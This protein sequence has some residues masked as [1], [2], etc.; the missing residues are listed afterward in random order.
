LDQ[1]VSKNIIPQMKIKSAF[2]IS[3]TPSAINIP[4]HLFTQL[5]I[6]WLLFY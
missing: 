6:I 1:Q 2:Y 5:F 4:I 3:Y